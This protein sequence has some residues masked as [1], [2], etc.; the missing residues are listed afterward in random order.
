MSCEQAQAEVE[1][2]I[3]ELKAALERYDVLVPVSKDLAAAWERFWLAA[4]AH[5]EA[6]KTHGSPRSSN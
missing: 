6:T 1:R 2:A 3:T 4:L 5:I